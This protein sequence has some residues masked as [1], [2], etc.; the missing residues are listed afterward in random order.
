[1]KIPGSYIGEE[2]VCKQERRNVHDPFAIKID[3]DIAKNCKGYTCNNKQVN[4][5]I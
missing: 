4:E 3:F 1:M 5:T 2:L